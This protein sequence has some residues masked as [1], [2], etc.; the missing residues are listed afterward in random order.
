MEKKCKCGTII[1]EIKKIGWTKCVC[2]KCGRIYYKMK[3][4]KHV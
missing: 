1:V 3:G 4:E 2:P